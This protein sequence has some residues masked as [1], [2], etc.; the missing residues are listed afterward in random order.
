MGDPGS[1]RGKRDLSRLRAVQ[2]Q[3]TWSKRVVLRWLSLAA[4]GNSLG[5]AGLSAISHRTAPSKRYHQ[6]PGQRHSSWF[7]NASGTFAFS[8]VYSSN[9][10]YK[11]SSTTINIPQLFFARSSTVGLTCFALLPDGSSQA[12]R[13]GLESYWLNRI[14]VGVLCSRMG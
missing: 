10:Y 6:K 9:R 7:V 14:G 4:A 12:R 3:S 11:Y 1:R 2:S 8:V 5:N 13:V